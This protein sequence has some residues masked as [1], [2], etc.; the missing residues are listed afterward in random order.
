MAFPAGLIGQVAELLARA[1][2]LASSGG[3]LTTFKPDAD[4]AFL[5]LHSIELTRMW[6]VPAPDFNRLAYRRKRGTRVELW[7][8]TPARDHRWDE[9]MVERKNLLIELRRLS[10]RA[11]AEHTIIVPA[12]SLALRLAA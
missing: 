11:P 2:V 1:S 5:D 9:F 7:F 4:V 6:L 3:R 10:P 12:R 8:K